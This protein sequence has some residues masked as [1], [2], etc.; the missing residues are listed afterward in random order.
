MN[1]SN[2]QSDSVRFVPR[3]AWLALGLTALSVILR[4]LCLLLFFDSDIGYYL[5][6][7][8]L[9][10]LSHILTAL[11]ALLFAAMALLWLRK[12]ETLRPV[13]NSDTLPLRITAGIAAVGLF[14][15]AVSDIIQNGK[16]WSG[17]LGLFACLY[18]LMQVASSATLGMRVLTALCVIARLLVMLASA[19]SD[20]MIP[21]NAP[22]KIF[23]LLAC[24]AF[25]LF[26]IGELRVS[27]SGVR[28][29]LYGFSLATAILLTATASI[30]AILASLTNGLPDDGYAIDFYVLLTLCV[31]AISRLSALALRPAA[32]DESQ[33]TDADE[34]PSDAQT[35]DD[36]N[37]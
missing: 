30:P 9:P 29:A 18:F 36:E 4:V 15:L 24:A 2:R 20:V 10:A 16:I 6:D 28:P 32:P 23:L 12:D 13:V 37:L 5:A 26:L 35:D 7:A 22:N 34:L 27:V 17:L 31:Y 1:H 14:S 8:A 21:M 19:Y 11:C 25:A 33:E 3:F